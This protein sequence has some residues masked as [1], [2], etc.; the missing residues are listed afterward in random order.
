MHQVSYFDTWLYFLIAFV[1]L[2]L[3]NRSTDKRLNEKYGQIAFLIIYA[4]AFFRYDFGNDYRAYWNLAEGRMGGE[5]E[6]YVKPLEII[7]YA[8]VKFVSVIHFPPLLFM[9]FSTI[10]LFSYRFVIKRYSSCQAF[11]WY[12][13]FTFPL[14]FFQDCSTVRQSGAMAMFFLAY[15]FLDNGK[16]FKSIVFFTIGVM[17]HQ[18]A[19][20]CFV[21]LLLPLYKKIGFMS[22]I[23][24][25]LM[26]LVGGKVVEIL[27]TDYLASLGIVDGLDFYLNNKFDGYNTFQY[28]LYAIAVINM[29]FYKKL[30]IVNCKNVE[31]ITL[32]N[33]GI[34]MYNLFSF[35]TQTAIRSCAFFLLFQLLLI[36]SYR[37][38]IGGGVKIANFTILFVMFLLQLMVVSIYISAYNNRILE[39]SVYSPYK[40]WFNYI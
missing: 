33:I 10:C 30:S 18:S 34:C 9:I 21:L 4:F 27:I 22:N 39:N 35:E 29:L 5:M 36:P 7:S 38:V 24:L 16:W 15:P 40:F 2:Y 11:S 17:F 14:L 8:I 3:I 6:D 20:F 1:F 12:F 13:Y 19:L 32:V 37:Y 25:L 23:V 31:Y 26:S 28:V